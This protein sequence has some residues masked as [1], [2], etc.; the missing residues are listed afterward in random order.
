M[1]FWFNGEIFDTEDKVIAV[2][3]RAFMLGDGLFETVLARDKV[4]LRLSAHLQS[5]LLYTS[6][7]ADE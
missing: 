5:C 4:P 7:A 3:D 6:D 2:D 1:K